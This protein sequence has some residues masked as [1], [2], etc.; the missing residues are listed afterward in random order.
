MWTGNRDA[1]PEQLQTGQVQSSLVLIRLPRV[2]SD[3]QNLKEA[4]EQSRQS[5]TSEMFLKVPSWN[6]KP[7]AAG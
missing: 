3:H 2:L 4:A 5:G 1:T 7:S 6:I